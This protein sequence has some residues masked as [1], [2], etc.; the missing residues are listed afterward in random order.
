MFNAVDSRLLG[1]VVAV[2]VLAVAEIGYQTAKRARDAGTGTP[3]AAGVQ[4]A[5]FT[6]VGLMLAFSFSLSLNRYDARRPAFTTERIAL[7]TVVQRTE[8]LDSPAAQKMHAYLKLYLDARIAFVEADADEKARAKSVSATDALQRE[9]WALTTAVA[10]KN[11]R[12]TEFPLFVSSLNGAFDA[13]GL[14][15]AVTSAHIPDPVM[16]VLIT[17]VL[18]AVGVLGFNTGSAGERNVWP[19]LLLGVTMGLVIGIILDLDHPQGGLIQVNFAPL[20]DDR[21]L[22]DSGPQSERATPYRVAARAVT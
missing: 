2:V 9:M 22:F 15:S 5:L 16:I 12:S 19:M 17:I 14:Q 7:G 10:R 20:I 21:Q 11:D 8:L 18:I 13:A 6:V 1:L 3:A 4:A